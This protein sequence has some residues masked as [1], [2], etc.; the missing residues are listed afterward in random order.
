MLH[1]QW[2]IDGAEWFDGKERLSQLCR[3][4]QLASVPFTDT[5]DNLVEHTRLTIGYI[6]DEVITGFSICLIVVQS[7]ITRPQCPSTG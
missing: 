4:T 5:A 7:V 1:V 3:D 6:I 2:V